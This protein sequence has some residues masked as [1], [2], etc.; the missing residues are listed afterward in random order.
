M[1]CRGE[2]QSRVIT[3]CGFVNMSN[4]FSHLIRCQYKQ[5]ISAALFIPVYLFAC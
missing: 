1:L 5:L 4:A 3:L 2:L